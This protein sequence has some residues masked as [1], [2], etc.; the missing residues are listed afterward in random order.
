MNSTFVRRLLAFTL[1]V[2]LQC[3]IFSKLPLGTYVQPCI[4]PLFVLL[5][6]AGYS[7]VKALLWAFML[8]LCIDLLSTDVIGI[9]TMATVA[10]ALIRPYVLKLFLSKSDADAYLFPTIRTL[11]IRPFTGYVL[12][13]MLGHQTLY[14][15]LDS[16]TLANSVHTFARI[17]LSTL[18]SATL[19]ILLQAAAPKIYKAA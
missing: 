17:A 12:L 4:Y 5:L 6:P 18:C 2:L 3:F 13:T 1:V 14:Y 15:M 11:G 19:V 9:N 10:L 8:G 7:Q 16:F